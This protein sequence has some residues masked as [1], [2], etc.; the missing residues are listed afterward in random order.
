MSGRARPRLLLALIVAVVL[1]GMLAHRVLRRSDRPLPALSPSA[2][3]EPLSLTTPT[4]TRDELSDLVAGANLVICV[5]DAAR[6]D[7]MGCYGYSRNTT[8][9]IDRLAAESVVFEHHFCQYPQ[10]K[11]STASLFTAL[12]PDSH[13]TFAKRTMARSTF[14]LA[15]GLKAAGFHNAF[16]SS[17]PWASPEMGIGEDFDWIR[18]IRRPVGGRPGAGGPGRG[19]AGPPGTLQ[20]PGR[21]IPASTRRPETLLALLEEW[22]EQAPPQPFSA[23]LHFMP[24]HT[25]Y[26]A[27]EEMKQ[28]FEG[29]PVPGYRRG[30]YPFSGI[31]EV[32]GASEH[33]SPGPD[34]VNLYDA[35]LL[36]ADWAVG[37]AE[38]LL[39]EAGLWENTLFILTSDHGET[40]GEHG[41]TWHPPCP[42]DEAIRI[43]LLIKFPGSSGP[44][45]RVRALTQTID[46]LPTVFE[47]YRLPYPAEDIQGRSLVSLITGETSGVH[48]YI[49]ARTGGNPPAYVV[50]GFHSALL[51]YEGGKRRA[52][53]DLDRDPGQTRN[54]IKQRPE[55][56]AELIE[57]FRAFAV[58]QGQPPLHFLDP[59]APT[60]DLP[61]VPE[62]TMSEE[63]RRELKALGY[64]K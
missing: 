25:P 30:K 31:T 51:L 21:G 58:A 35:N 7:H 16:F 56:A 4:P 12:Y 9:N 60:A 27:P 40:F 10:T 54:I 45:G 19:R 61:P 17:N 34:L 48:S 62:V 32:G 22:L 28:V 36:W 37:E 26:E 57:A 11:P 64:L 14:T 53:Y 8:P 41:Y 33:D 20:A 29:K 24:P 46:L 6:V 15:E 43:P 63:S 39:R 3:P 38:R 18:P 2:A 59:D 49:F 52:L 1:L 13:L 23:Y 50:R 47:L 5:I 55:R 44:V 42:Y